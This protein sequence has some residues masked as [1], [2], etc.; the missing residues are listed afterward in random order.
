[1]PASI[2]SPER[3]WRAAASPVIAGVIGWVVTGS[4]QLGLRDGIP[5]GL[6][7]STRILLTAG[8]VAI[9]LALA[10]LIMR[11]RLVLTDEGLCDRRLFRVVRIPWELIAEF[12]IGRPGGLWGGF[13]VQAVRRDGARVDLMSTRAY[14]RIPSAGHLDELHRISWTLQ[15]AASD[16]AKTA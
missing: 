8:A 6:F 7:P 12:E 10:V 13:C 5:A 1:M 16:A 4:V 14:S 15:Q 3:R 2:A 9:G 11:T